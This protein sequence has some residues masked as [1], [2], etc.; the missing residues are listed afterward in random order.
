MTYSLD[1]KIEFPQPLILRN[2][3][4]RSDSSA[5]GIVIAEDCAGSRF[6]RLS[7]LGNQKSLNAII[8]TSDINYH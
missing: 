7:F 8:L 4:E 5:Y 3:K 6:I 1:P 2:I